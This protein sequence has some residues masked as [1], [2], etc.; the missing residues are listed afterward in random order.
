[1]GI[2]QFDPRNPLVEG[3]HQRYVARRDKGGFSQV[4]HGDRGR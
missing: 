3:F 1:V 2:D 4:R